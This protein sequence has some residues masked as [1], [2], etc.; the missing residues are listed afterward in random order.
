MPRSIITIMNMATDM[1]T[2]TTGMATIIP[3]RTIMA[4]ITTTTATATVTMNTSTDTGTATA[5]PW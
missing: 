4:D 1:I 3:M 2:T 5:K